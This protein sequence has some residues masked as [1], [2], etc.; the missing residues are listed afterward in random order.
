MASALSPPPPN[1]PLNGTAI[2]ILLFFICGFPNVT[3]WIRNRHD[4][5]E[6]G[7][8]VVVQRF[9]VQEAFGYEA[10]ILAVLLVL[11]AAHLRIEEISLPW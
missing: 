11:L 1:P 5:E 10:E 8:H 4:V 2:K 6:E 7:L 9:V 3:F